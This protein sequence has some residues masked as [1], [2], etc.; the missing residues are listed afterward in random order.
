VVAPLYASRQRAGENDSSTLA[1]SPV[2]SLAP[3]SPV[4]DFKPARP[5]A[6]YD[7]FA[8]PLAQFDLPNM[9]AGAVNL[10]GDQSRAGKAAAFLAFGEVAASVD[11]KFCRS[12]IEVRLQHTTAQIPR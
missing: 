10:L 5:L 7:D 3:I 4:L 11:A 1:R 2:Q 12:G 8:V 6:L 9:A